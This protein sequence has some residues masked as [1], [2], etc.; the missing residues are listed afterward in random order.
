MWTF[1]PLLATEAAWL[2]RIF[3]TSA[4]TLD[5]VLEE[6]KD[7]KCLRGQLILTHFS[8]QDVV[9]KYS[10]STDNM[11]VT[12]NFQSYHEI[13]AIYNT[14]KQ[15]KLDSNIRKLHLTELGYFIN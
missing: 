5:R 2:N 1:I 7:T 14:L 12:F 4:H 8:G 11:G 3:K 13:E 10:Y 6:I 9:K 15:S